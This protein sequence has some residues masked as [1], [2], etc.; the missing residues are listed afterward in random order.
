M[1]RALAEDLRTNYGKNL[2]HES[3]SSFESLKIRIN[4][5]TR[6]L[7]FLSGK[8]RKTEALDVRLCCCVIKSV[9]VDFMYSLFGNELEKLTFDVNARAGTIKTV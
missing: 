7:V 5:L 4:S 9:F 8:M 3:T 1:C 6:F 2:F